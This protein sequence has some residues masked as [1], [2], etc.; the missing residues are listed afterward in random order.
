MPTLPRPALGMMTS[1]FHAAEARDAYAHHFRAIGIPA[2]A[3]GA[4]SMRKA[5]QKPRMTDIPAI[6]RGNKQD[7]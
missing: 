7:D 2:V 5:P 4:Y 3:A 1:N 6:L